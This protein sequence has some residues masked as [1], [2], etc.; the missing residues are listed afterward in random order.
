MA[1]E[2]QKHLWADIGNAP[3]ACGVYAWYYS[4]EITEFDLERTIETVRAA[5]D[6]TEAE[7]AIRT[8]L[9]GRMF[10]YFREEPYAA[11]VS[12]PLKPTYTGSLRHEPTASSSLVKRLLDQ[13]ERLRTIRDVLALSAPM[14]ASPLYIGMATVLRTRLAQHKRLIESF[15]TSEPRDG[16]VSR[17]RDA[18]FAWQIAQ[19]K[20]PPERLFVFTCLTPSDSDTAVDI[21]NILNR[22]CYPILGRN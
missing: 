16:E 1:N 15:R 14:F 19:R 22:I 2:I 21:E 18:G 7:Q 11:S 3:Q 10:R 17:G 5:S 4:P 13:P 12:G 9:D 20:I 6:S 8:T